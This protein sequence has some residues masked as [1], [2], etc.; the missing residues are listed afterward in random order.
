MPATADE[1]RDPSLI[2][3][4]RGGDDGVPGMPHWLRR[5]DHWATRTGDAINPILVKETRQ[6]LKSRQFVTTFSLLL[7]ASLAWTIVGSLLMMPQIYYT[8]SGQR[9]L[10]GYYFVLAVPMLLVV[11]LAAY[12][13]LEGE[14]DDGT[15]ELL[16]ITS[17]SPRQIVTGKLASAALQML[18][19]FVALFPSVAYAYT[20]RGV[21]LPTI[22]LLIGILIVSGLGLTMVA[23]AL[24]PVSGGRLGQIAS[25]LATLAVL[26]FAEFA[27]GAFAMDLIEYGI[28]VESGELGF[29]ILSPLLFGGSFAAILLFVTA[30]KLTPE[31]ENRS[32]AIRIAVLV[33]VF[34][35]IVISAAAVAGKEDSSANPILS[36]SE[37]F[38]ILAGPYLVAFFTIVG[39]M[40]SAES[41]TMTPRIRREL[42]GTFLG[43]LF[44][45]WLTPGPATGLVFSVVTLAVAAIALHLLLMRAIPPGSW[46]ASQI[47]QHRKLVMLVIPY[48]MFALVGVRCIISFL[49]SRNPVN[50]RVGIAAM[51]VMLLLMALIPYAIGMHLND[52]RQ[53]E[54]SA[55]QSSNWIWTIN[56]SMAGTLDPVAGYLVLGAGC[57]AFLVHLLLLGQRVLPQRLATPERVLEEYRRMAGWVPPAEEETDPLGLGNRDPNA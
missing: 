25:L 47:D 17:L 53:F 41:P 30:A 54:Y 16:T 12:R 15:L 2:E 23:L 21:D 34:C 52:Y 55:W 22:A 20:L 42:P 36:E 18:L 32:T 9:M 10:L 5:L 51:A 27:I 57:G 43:R 11:P 29:L 49:R 40:M 7:F 1:R 8:P 44:L 48:L 33:H 6:A 37:A 45:T 56:L 3:I 14:V 35:V 39:S 31:S 50:P 38:P 13:S 19:Y 4:L 28:P 46:M 24:A 26:I